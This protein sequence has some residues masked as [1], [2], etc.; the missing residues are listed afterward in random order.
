MVLVVD[1]GQQTVKVYRALDD[2]RILQGEAGETQVG[3]D[4]V[5]GWG[6]PVAE[7]FV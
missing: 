7:S 5:P 4:V 2:L 3:A 1:P 6:L